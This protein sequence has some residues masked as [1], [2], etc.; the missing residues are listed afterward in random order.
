[1][2]YQLLPIVLMLID[3]STQ[4]YTTPVTEEDKN[5]AVQCHNNYRSQLALGNVEN[6]TGGEK[7][8]KASNMYKLTWDEN[9]ANLSQE[10][11][12]KCLLRH[13]WNGWAGENL[14]Y[15]GGT[16][17]NK[18]AF[19]YACIRWWRELGLYGINQELTLDGDSLESIGHWTN[20]AWA[21]TDRIGCAVA[22]NCPNT[23][24]KTY[25]VCWYY[26]GGNY[27]GE[28][29]YGVGEPCSKCDKCDKSTGLCYQ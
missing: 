24:W 12:N 7:M 18:D 8:P 10:W 5:A 26:K 14:A 21:N 2:I 29:V 11:A 25:I 6:K 1:M 3:R 27:L 9:L 28:P 23:N 4:Q 16:F 17:T 15:N 19:E 22:R 13:S 20:M